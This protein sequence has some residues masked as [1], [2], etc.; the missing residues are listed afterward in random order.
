MTS[1]RNDGQPRIAAGLALAGLEAIE[2]FAERLECARQDGLQIARDRQAAISTSSST[3]RCAFSPSHR[4]KSTGITASQRQRG[5]FRL[6]RARNPTKRMKST[7]I[8]ALRMSPSDGVGR[9]SAGG[10]H[11]KLTRSQ[12]AGGEMKRAGVEPPAPRIE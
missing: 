3:C 8:A 2:N 4:K 12:P 11:P 6:V 1:G 10:I 7:A 9:N 5:A